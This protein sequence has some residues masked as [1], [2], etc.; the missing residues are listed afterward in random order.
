[1]NVLI[2]LRPELLEYF[3][4]DRLRVIDNISGR[5]LLSKGKPDKKFFSDHLPLFFSL[6]IEKEI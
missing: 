4:D 3:P 1:L 2:L 6:K 5:S